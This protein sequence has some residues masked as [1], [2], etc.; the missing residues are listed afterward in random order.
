MGNH[1]AQRQEQRVGWPDLVI[2][3]IVILFAY[4]GW[5]RGFVD[6]IGG[7]IALAAAVWAAIFYP[8]TLDGVMHGYFGLNTGSA[9]I[10]GMIA[11]ALVV[12]I[13]LMAL[14]MLLSRIAKLPLIGIGNGIGGACIG[15]AK[16][17]LGIWA[18]LYVLLFFP[19]AKDLRRDLRASPLVATVTGPNA[20]VDAFLRGTMPW[21]VRAYATP[22][23]ARHRL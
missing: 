15:A 21:F 10:V 6:E 12:Y 1:A 11:F 7:F 19:L 2:V 20:Q 8:G 22:V 14:S 3:I 16:A 13:A 18:V 17:L 23:F 5:R 4:K 9:H